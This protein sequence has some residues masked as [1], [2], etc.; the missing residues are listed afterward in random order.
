MSDETMPMSEELRAIIERLHHQPEEVQ[1]R[2]AD[3]VNEVLDEQ[4]LD[5]VE[6]T[7]EE[8]EAIRLSEAELADGDYMTWDECMH[9]RRS[10]E[11]QQ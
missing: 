5:E 6:P 2:I 8:E 9:E 7:P 10:Q 4:G 3:L 11:H 1:R